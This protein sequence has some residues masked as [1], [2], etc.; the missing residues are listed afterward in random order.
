MKLW[1]FIYS[2]RHTARVVGLTLWAMALCQL[3]V[4]S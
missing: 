4:K 2:Y 1:L 3:V